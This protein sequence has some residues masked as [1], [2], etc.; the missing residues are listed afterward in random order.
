MKNKSKKEIINACVNYI[1]EMYGKIDQTN[2]EK[3]LIDNNRIE[4]VPKSQKK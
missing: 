1:N 2:V 3:W 4:F